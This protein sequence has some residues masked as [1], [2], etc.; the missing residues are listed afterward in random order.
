MESQYIPAAK[1]EA[2]WAKSER[3]TT[4][5][6]RATTNQ[7]KVDTEQTLSEARTF[8]TSIKGDT[9]V[10]REKAE[11]HMV[12]A[13]AHKEKAIAEANKTEA[14]AN[15]AHGEADRAKGY[16]EKYKPE[17]KGA[18]TFDNYVEWP[19]LGYGQGRGAIYNDGTTHKCLMVHGNNSAGTGEYRVGLWNHVTVYGDLFIKEHPAYHRGNIISVAK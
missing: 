16:V 6:I 19:T 17:V 2:D 14:E 10:I 5:Q 3:E 9:E 18:W 8:T 4:E 15:R 11:Q 13:H 1:A 7:L 12:N